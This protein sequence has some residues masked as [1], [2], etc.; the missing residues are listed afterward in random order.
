MKGSTQYHRAAQLVLGSWLAACS[1]GEGHPRRDGHPRGEGHSSDAG[2]SRGEE[3]SRDD[4]QPTSPAPPDAPEA[5]TRAS[6]APTRTSDAPPGAATSAGERR[7]DAL[8]PLAGVWREPLSDARGDVG[9]V[10][11]PIGTTTKRPLVVALHAALDHPSMTCSEWRAMFGPEPFI[12]CPYGER[13]N[14]TSY[15]WGDPAKLRASIDR[16]VAAAEARFPQRIERAGAV[17]AS[18][19]QSGILSADALA[20]PGMEFRYALLFEG[21]P[22][23]LRPLRSAFVRAGIRR[24]LIVNQQGGW[25]RAHLAAAKSLAPAIEAKHLVFGDGSFGHFMRGDTFERMHQEL[26]WLVAGDPV[27]DI[28]R[29]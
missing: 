29:P 20:K 13:L 23:D 15:V 3:R 10:A 1:L 21:V 14:A 6:E 16:A 27:W 28:L 5:P 26:P 4:G 12:V 24:V 8:P 18:Y 19:S 17:W 7:S 22:R 11:V 2:R 25:S 9:F